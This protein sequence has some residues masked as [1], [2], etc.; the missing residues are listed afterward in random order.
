MNHLLQS[1]AYQ[2]IS[3]TTYKTFISKFQFSYISFLYYYFI[4]CFIGTILD[5]HRSLF[6]FID[7]IFLY[8]QHLFY[9]SFLI[10]T[11]LLLQTS[12]QMQAISLIIISLN[13]KKLRRQK[14]ITQIMFKSSRN[15]N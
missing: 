8:Y 5:F 2:K 11:L 6:L 1:C 15:S 7:F 12:S 4:S 10:Y 14:P 3:K 9:F 13:F